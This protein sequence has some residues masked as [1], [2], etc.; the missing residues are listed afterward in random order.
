MTYK[1]YG[2][3]EPV[4]IIHGLFGMLD[5]WQT[6]AKA[7]SEEYHVITLDLRNHGRSFH[8]E[9]MNFDAMCADIIYLMEHLQISRAHFIGHSLGGKVAMHMA[10]DF[11]QTV[12]KLIVVDVAPYEYP[13]Y[14]TQVFDALLAVP[15]DKMESRQEVEQILRR[16]LHQEGEIQFLMKGLTRDES[17]K[18]TWKF[19][20]PVLYNNYLPL[21]QHISNHPFD[22]PTLFIK[23][24][25]SSYITVDKSTLIPDL[26]PHFEIDVVPNAGHWVHAD[27]PAAFIELIK[28]FLSK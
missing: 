13:P 23:G 17:G 11:P 8:D 16:H 25:H 7:L 9:E 12:D 28:A 2:I 21:I 14:H 4:F 10:S 1:S 19:N 5:N 18:F 22:G 3:G 15:L 24:E 27:N 6:V 26:F 20:L